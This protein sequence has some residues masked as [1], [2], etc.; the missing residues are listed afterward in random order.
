MLFCG[1]AEMRIPS[2]VYDT[3]KETVY[4]EDHLS[5]VTGLDSASPLGSAGSHQPKSADL[6]TLRLNVSKHFHWHQS[7]Q[8]RCQD[9][10]L[11]TLTFLIFF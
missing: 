2:H 1:R 8:K 7:L 4:K 6:A 11:K 9:T 10:N 3:D 5:A